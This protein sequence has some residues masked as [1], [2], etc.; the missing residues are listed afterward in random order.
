MRGRH[1]SPDRT[2]IDGHKLVVGQEVKDVVDCIVLGALC[3]YILAPEVD[4]ITVQP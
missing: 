4:A 3:W 1:V 2:H